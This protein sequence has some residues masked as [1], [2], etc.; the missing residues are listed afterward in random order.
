VSL[1]NGQ[2]TKPTLW[3]T[4][5]VANNK[6]TPQNAQEA[7][8]LSVFPGDEILSPKFF[9]VLVLFRFSDVI[10]KILCVS[11]TSAFVPDTLRLNISG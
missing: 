4:V 6:R 5:C 10:I 7:W 11:L 8:E 3:S 9:R 2:S 1:V